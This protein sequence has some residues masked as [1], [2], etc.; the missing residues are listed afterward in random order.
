MN[1]FLKNP[2]KSLFGHLLVTIY[3]IV[4][5]GFSEAVD[6]LSWDRARMESFEL[7]KLQSIISHAYEHSLLYRRLYDAA[8]VKPSDLKSLS[9]IQKFPIVTKAMIREGIAKGTIFTLEQPPKDVYVTSTTGSSGDPLTLSFDGGSISSRTLNGVRSLWSMGALPT[10]RFAFLWRNKG[11]SR[12]QRIRTK[13]GLF[14]FVPVID[15]MQVQHTAL[16][17]DLMMK[18]VLDLAAFRPQIIRGYTSALWA[19]ARFVEKN[20]IAIRPE[21]IIASAEYMPP[22]WQEDM[23]KIFKC[24][25][26]NLYGGTEASTISATLPNTKGMVAFQD[27]TYTEIVDA[28]NK[29]EKPGATGRIL[30]TDYSNN[31]MPVIRYEIGDMGSWSGDYAGPFPLM[32][33][34]VGRINDIF[35]LPGGKILF[36]H[37]WPLYFREHA[38]ISKFVVVQKK[39][40]LVEI[41]LELLESVGWNEE[42]CEIKK[43]VEEAVGSEVVIDWK[44]VDHIELGPGEK[45]RTLRSELDPKVILENL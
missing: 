22:S 32:K 28:R 36:S 8:G 1:P 37:S 17:R 31:Y 41:M 26:Y 40:N 16:G 43:T 18:T 7:E 30:V 19:I 21:C 35:V 27:F 24:P 38:I 33:E 4:K 29:T 14:K 15:V 12:M 10:K 45:F 5:P 13:M 20:N 2:I 23:E 44:I 6:R 25:V 3:G 42:M 11:L 34:V 39:L 9:D